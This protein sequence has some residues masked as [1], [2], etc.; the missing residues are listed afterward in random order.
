[1]RI[2]L[3]VL[4]LLVS[5]SV[6]AQELP[7]I[8]IQN[9]QSCP[10]NWIRVGDI[11]EQITMTVRVGGR[12]I[13]LHFLKEEFDGFFRRENG[14]LDTDARDGALKASNTRS[15]RYKDCEWRPMPPANPR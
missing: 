7:R 3:T 6:Q 5:V 12:N 13:R 9:S 1:M 11:Y 10:E 15:R 2:L 8:T 4:L 14:T